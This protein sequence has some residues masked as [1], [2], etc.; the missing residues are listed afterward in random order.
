M[1]SYN[2]QIQEVLSVVEEPQTPVEKDV[3]VLSTGVEL[4]RKEFPIMRVQAVAE[5]FPYP[6]VP[7]V[8]NEEKQRKER[9]AGSEEYVKAVEEVD[10]RRGLAV[11]DTVMAVGTEVV[12]I[13]E[14]FPTP[15]SDE[16]IEELEIS[17]I[18]VKRESKVARY[19]A[20]IKYVAT[21]NE[22]DLVKIMSFATAQMGSSE[23][24]VAQQLQQNFQDN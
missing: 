23:A 7:L 16:W 15:D 14:G 13:P 12:Y 6:E 18:T 21:K 20:W 22:D 17:H 8:W 10:R 11:V 3:I 19:H 5:M 24:N 4:K 2:E 1:E 9:W